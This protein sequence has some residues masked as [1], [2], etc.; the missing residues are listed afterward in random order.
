MW[1]AGVAQSRQMRTIKMAV[2]VELYHMR[3]NGICIT[4]TEVPHMARRSG[5][6][7]ST[8]LAYRCCVDDGGGGG[9]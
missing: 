2:Y 9:E 4:A 8:S 6:E 5:G 7:G 3:K 1:S